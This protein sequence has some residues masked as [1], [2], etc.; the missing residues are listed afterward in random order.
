MALF[1]TFEALMEHRVETVEIARVALE[2]RVSDLDARVKDVELGAGPQPLEG[3]V[4]TTPTMVT[5]PPRC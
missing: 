3:E 1:A 5:S 4:R 2:G